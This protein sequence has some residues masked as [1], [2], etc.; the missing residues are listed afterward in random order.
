MCPPGI[1]IGANGGRLKG[2]PSC[3]FAGVETSVCEGRGRLLL[4]V[5]GVGRNVGALGLSLCLA[6]IPAATCA[7]T[8]LA[9][10]CGDRNAGD[11]CGGDGVDG[12]S[13]GPA[14][15]RRSEGANF[16]LGVLFALSSV[17]DA[18]IVVE[19]RV[20]GVS[21]S[22]SSGRNADDAC[23]GGCAVGLECSPAPRIR[24]VTI[25]S[26]FVCVFRSLSIRAWLLQFTATVVAALM[27]LRWTRATGGVALAGMAMA[28]GRA[29]VVVES[30]RAL[31]SEVTAETTAGANVAGA[32]AVAIVVAD[33]PI[34]SDVTRVAAV[35][36]FSGSV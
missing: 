5:G 32:R 24:G 18:M 10:D 36:V 8:W 35:V 3:A 26:V 12:V 2:T 15:R 31:V 25:R 9:S 7:A 34:V 33:S 14:P 4:A 16:N 20:C 1:G 29:V 17:G 11:A 23:G 22:W 13:C 27:G 30:A 19:F 28:G 6:A 21:G